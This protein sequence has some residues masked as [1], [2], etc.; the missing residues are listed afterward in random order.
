MNIRYFATGEK[1]GRS[2]AGNL[3]MEKASGRYLNFLD[4]DDLFFADH[5]EVLVSQL[6]K[7]KKRAAYC[8][9]LRDPGGDTQ[10]GSIRV[11]SK[12]VQRSL[13]HRNSIK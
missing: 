10:Q 1:V 3:G 9:C 5:V 7:G 12:T 4:D 8:V 11:Y 2:R 13:T 6:I